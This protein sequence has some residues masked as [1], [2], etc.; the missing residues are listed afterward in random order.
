[1]LRKESN[2]QTKELRE[3]VGI[4]QIMVSRSTNRTSKKEEG[5]GR[6]VD[7]GKKR[8]DNT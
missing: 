1:M 5:R 6:I 8:Q 2:R 4:F 7:N 3:E